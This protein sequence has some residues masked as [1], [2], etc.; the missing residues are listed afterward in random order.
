[1]LLGTKQAAE[2]EKTQQENQNQVFKTIFQPI[3]L[4]VCEVSNKVFIEK[5][6]NLKKQNKILRKMFGSISASG[7]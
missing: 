6:Y 7:V 4:Y 5:A 2:Q 3:I 1:M